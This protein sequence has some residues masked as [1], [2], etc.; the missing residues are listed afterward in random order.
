MWSWQ[1]EV[2]SIANL[3]L[4]TMTVFL[5]TYKGFIIRY[6][7][8]NFSRNP[9]AMVPLHLTI[10]NKIFIRREAVFLFDSVVLLAVGAL[11]QMC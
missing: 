5:E 2:S 7:S 4:Y 6:L 10:R 11:Q 1:A 3:L 9:Y 8:D